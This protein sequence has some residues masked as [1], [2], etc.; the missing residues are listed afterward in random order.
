MYATDDG[1]LRMTLEDVLSLPFCHLLSGLDEGAAPIDRCGSQTTLSGYT[2]WIA[3]TAPP[4]TV[5][6]D[7]AVIDDQWTRV[8]PP[9]SNVLLVDPA[10]HPYDW[11]KNELVMGTV[12]DAIPWQER[13]RS[14]IAQ[15]YGAKRD[16]SHL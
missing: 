15:R 14:A 13:A 10:R 7:W 12:A 2:E 6:W 8:G 16:G 11:L 5:G 1:F 3:R 9:R 4:V